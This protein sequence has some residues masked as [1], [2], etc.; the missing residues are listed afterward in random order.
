MGFRVFPY[1]PD[2]KVEGYG[3]SNKGID[4][5]CET[6]APELIVAVDH[7]IVAKQYVAY[8]AKKGVPVVVIDHHQKDPELFPS[9]ALCLFYSVDYSAAALS[10][11]VA[12]YIYQ[13]M[14]ETGMLTASQVMSLDRLFASDLLALAALGLIADVIPLTGGARSIAFH[15]LKAFST[16]SMP[17]LQTLCSI[18][19]VMKKE[20]RSYEIGFYLAPR[21]NAFGRIGEALDGVRLLCA[22]TMQLAERFGIVAQE[23]NKKR[24]ALV[25]SAMRSIGKNVNLS[26]SFVVAL[27]EG[28]EEGILGLIAGKLA[29]TYGRPALALTNGGSGYKASGRSAAGFAMTDFLRSLPV[30]FSSIGGHDGACGLT[31]PIDEYPHLIE[32]LSNSTVTIK[33]PPTM[34]DLDIPFSVITHSLFQTLQKM[35]PFGAGNPDPLFFSKSQLD[36]MKSFGK[37]SQ[38]LKYSFRD[39][40]NN[41]LDVIH[42]NAQTS[43]LRSMS[44][45]PC[46]IFFTLDEDTY[47]YSPSAR[48]LYHS[49]AAAL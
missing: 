23:L 40:K 6:H 16:I 30:K 15:G 14:K 39:A 49:I 10:Y 24:Q 1:I 3:F 48:G 19:G 26:S 25:E 9:N 18:S 44:G 37:T 17:G 36:G 12:H 29:S 38:H 32:T 43:P 47:G 11:F 7:G 4:H 33:A 46:G 8:A 21:L 35:A 20:L 45:E 2:R 41:F 27:G 13:H 22:P 42:F 34:A 5:V 28:W 31:I